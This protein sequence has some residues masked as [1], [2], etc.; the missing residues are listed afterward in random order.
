M[1]T[2]RLF[3]AGFFYLYAKVI[4]SQ[5][6]K[7]IRSLQ[8]KKYRDRHRLFVVEGDKMV[9]ELLASDFHVDILC[10]LRSWLDTHQSL[11]QE[12]TT[13]LALSP[14]ELARVSGMK[15]AHQV[16]AVVRQPE[17]EMP[18][19]HGGDDLILL[20]D[21]IRDPGNLG[22]ILRTADWFGVKDVY[23]S[24]ET[25]EVYNPKIIQA[26]MA[27]FLRVRTHYTDLARLIR[28]LRGSVRIYGSYMDGP[29][30]LT[31]PLLLPAAV[32]IGNEARG[33]SDPLTS[34][35]DERLS[36]PAYSPVKGSGAGSGGAPDSLN[37]AMAA[38]IILSCFRRGAP[39]G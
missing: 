16:L 29:D 10:A 25:V 30:V 24:P 3:P 20:L 27:S 4:T 13:C 26:S 1:K 11:L 14:G 18:S 38:G 17:T 28:N 19:H 31:V 34:L 22:S 5:Q 36:I 2:C 39:A 21:D 6:I 12:G 8:Q 37:A 23:C 33:I 32:V 35:M 15:T 9:R 7:F